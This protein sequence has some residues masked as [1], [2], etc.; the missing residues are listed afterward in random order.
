VVRRRRPA[1]REVTAYAINVLIDYLDSLDGDPD[2]EPDVDMDVNKHCLGTP[3]QP[4][5]DEAAVVPIGAG[6]PRRFTQ[7]RSRRRVAPAHEGRSIARIEPHRLSGRRPSGWRR[8][9]GQHRTGG[10]RRLRGRVLA[11]VRHR[12]SPLAR[13]IAGGHAVMAIAGT[14]PGSKPKRFWRLALIKARL[15]KAR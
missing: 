15:T 7:R 3:L 2:L 1:T 9:V 4:K 12:L 13:A 11:L 6:T 10:C 8:H 14:A 5:Q